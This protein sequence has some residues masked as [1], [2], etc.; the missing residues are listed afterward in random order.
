AVGHRRGESNH[1]EG[2]R[3]QIGTGSLCQQRRLEVNFRAIE[4]Q[5]FL[6]RLKELA[7]LGVLVQQQCTKVSHAGPGEVQERRLSSADA[8]RSRLPPWSS[9]LEV[10]APPINGE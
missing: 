8:C 1:Q 7:A 10:N 5:A 4:D 3:R 9:G 2:L 6:G